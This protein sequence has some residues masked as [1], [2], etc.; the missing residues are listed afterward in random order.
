[1]S[2]R[3]KMCSMNGRNVQITFVIIFT[4]TA[5]FPVRRICFVM[6]FAS[7]CNLCTEH[8]VYCRL[9][10]H[11]ICVCTGKWVELGIYLLHTLECECINRV[12]LWFHQVN[13]VCLFN[14]IKWAFSLSHFHTR[15]P[16]CRPNSTTIRQWIEVTI[17][18]HTCSVRLQFAVANRLIALVM[19]HNKR[20]IGTDFSF[21]T[22]MSSFFQGFLFSSIFYS[23][24]FALHISMKR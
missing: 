6:R 12:L 8:G 7:G 16:S 5:F 13:T 4:C 14:C 22:N 9:F 1:M 19:R 24:R 2:K 18:T 10:A 17:H 3:F 11:L 20:F 23:N 21:H 15:L